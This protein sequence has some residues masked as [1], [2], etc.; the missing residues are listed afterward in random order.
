MGIRS[1]MRRISLGW[2][3]QE[4]DEPLC[5]DDLEETCCETGLFVWKDEWVHVG[6]TMQCCWSDATYL[7]YSGQWLMIYGIPWWNIYV[8]MEHLCIH[9]MFREYSWYIHGTSM[10]YLWNTY[11]I[12][13]V[14]YVRYL[15]QGILMIYGFITSHSPFFLTLLYLIEVLTC[16]W[17]YSQHWARKYHLGS[18]YDKV[19]GI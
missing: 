7:L 14:R 4:A 3:S 16:M 15:T 6:S 13:K 5:A 1:T 2:R 12:P 18:R 19:V 11:G 10:K 8:F 17:P 9:G